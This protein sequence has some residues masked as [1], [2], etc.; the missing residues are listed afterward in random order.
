MCVLEVKVTLGIFMIKIWRTGTW[1]L[2]IQP[3]SLRSF[4]MTK[5]EKRE[6]LDKIN[7][8]KEKEH[9]PTFKL[10]K[11]VNAGEREWKYKTMM[12][13][14]DQRTLLYK[15]STQLFFWNRRKAI[16]RC[17]NEL[18]WRLIC[19][20]KHRN[21]DACDIS[22]LSYCWSVR[23]ICRTISRVKGFNGIELLKE[24]LQKY[25]MKSTR[26]DC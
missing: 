16:E 21:M 9:N 17:L 23:G 2:K 3:R 11:K 19:F 14:T 15:E 7:D 8:F 26:D 5:R 6:E 10:K 4:V 13:D 22:H 25:L 20:N 24:M 1:K 18:V 12:K